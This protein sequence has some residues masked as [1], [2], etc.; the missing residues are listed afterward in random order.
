MNKKCTKCEII[1]PIDEF[2]RDNHRPDGKCVRCKACR[3]LAYLANKEVVAAASAKHYRDNKGRHDELSLAYYY[4]NQRRRSEKMAEWYRNNVELVAANVAAYR[5]AH[6]GFGAAKTAQRRAHEIK[7]TPPWA[8]IDAIKA[9]YLEAARLTRVTGVPHHVDH[10]VPLRGKNV[11][12]L[13]V[14]GNLQIL[15]AKE[16]VSKSNKFEA[17]VLAA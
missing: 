4:A 15:T 17:L 5:A 11:C 6:P 3:R 9:I 12:G 13:H 16:N 14:E 1:K 10:I 8:N 2:S 7:A